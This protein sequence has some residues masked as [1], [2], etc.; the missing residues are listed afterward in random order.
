VTNEARF[1]TRMTALTAVVAFAFAALVTRLWFLQVLAAE[2]YRGAAETNRVRLVPI[3]APRGE[4]LDRHGEPLVINHPTHVITVDLSK[5]RNERGL[6]SRLSEVLGVSTAEL[7]R[8]L[9]DP[10]FLPYQPVPVHQ[11]ASKREILSIVERPQEFPGVDYQTIGVRRYVHGDLAPHLLGY[12]GEI[13]PEELEDPSFADHV[14]GQLVGRDGVEQYYEH[15]LHGEDG[16]LKLEVDS[17][18]NVIGELSR[19]APAPGNQ[20]VLSIDAEIQELA[21]DTLGKAAEA[22]RTIYDDGIGGYLEASA[23]AV[24]VLDPDTGHVLA[25]ASFPS[26]DPRVFQDEVTTKEW[27]KLNDPKRNYP[28]TNR[29]VAGLYPPASA[30]KPFVAAAALKGG[31][32]EQNQSFP[33]PPTFTVPGDTSGTVFRN[34][35]DV[36]LGTLSLSES[37]VQSCDTVYYDF[38]LAFYADRDTRGEF[39][40]QQ[41]RQWGFGEITGIDVSG[42]LPGRV[43][44]EQWKEEINQAYPNLYPFG[45]WLPGDDINMSI[46]QGDIL[47]TP[48]QLASA[49]AAIANGGTLYRPQVALRIERPDGTVVKEIEPQAIGRAPAKEEDLRF[50]RQALTGVVSSPSGTAA[51]AFAGFPFDE[52]S[53]AGKTGT[54]EVIVDGKDALHSWFAGMAPAEDPEYVVVALMEQGG[55]GSQVAAPIVRQVLEGLLDLE[56]GDF[57]IETTTTD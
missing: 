26:Y 44:D 40:Q 3:P 41:I 22:A 9:H 27:D 30:F 24:V 53:V 49:Y 8:R 1:R 45:F 55:H 33:C 19:R 50:L 37:L 47:V 21:Q 31:Y 57:E 17:S 39:F 20:L 16:V 43:P 56:P 52:V 28:L 34:W 35:T 46:G 6:L 10:D 13:S 2:E 14:P 7:S 5:V 11:G 38:G 18:G 4:I 25:M 51:T 23:G 54:A 42:E 32:A 36:D 29:A 12:L 48:L 15:F